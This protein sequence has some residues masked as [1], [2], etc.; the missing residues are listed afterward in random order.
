MTIHVFTE[1]E[2][3]DEGFPL[4]R[5]ACPLSAADRDDLP[6]PSHDDEVLFSGDDAPLPSG[7][8]ASGVVVRGRPSA[9]RRGLAAG[10]SVGRGRR[11]GD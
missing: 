1:A 9:T 5:C 11:R 6:P 10:M 4:P 3:H 2:V 7:R 8:P